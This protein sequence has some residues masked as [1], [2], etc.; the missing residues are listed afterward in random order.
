[1]QAALDYL[2]TLHNYNQVLIKN[3]FRNMSA[4]L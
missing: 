3:M 1:M 4:I 2:I